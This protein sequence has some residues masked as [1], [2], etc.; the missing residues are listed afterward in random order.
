VNGLT[1]IVPWLGTALIGAVFAV[2]GYVGKML[3]D[4]RKE[5]RARRDKILLQLRSLRSLLHATAVLFSHQKD[6]VG[7]LENLL[8]NS[9]P[10]E[11]GR[12]GPHED[13]MTCCYPVM[14]AQERDLHGIIRS[15]TQY[16][17]RGLNQA[18]SKWL[19]EDTNFKPGAIASSRSREL[20]KQLFALE[21]HL[22]LWHAKY[23]SW[24]PNHPEHAL[25]YLADENEHGLG[26]P[27]THVKEVSG[28]TVQVPGVEEEVEMALIELRAKWK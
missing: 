12:G 6:Q 3:I 25:V 19:E 20:A 5:K 17:L 1:N 2:A 13:V 9:H 4:Q 18:I 27:R 11:Y 24:I 28:R 10:A 22:L 21:I 16:S 7:R 23:E 26:F 15:T 14:N 8:E